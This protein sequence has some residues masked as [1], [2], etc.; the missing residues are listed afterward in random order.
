MSKQMT[1]VRIYISESDA[2]RKG[3]LMK[4]IMAVLHDQ[5]RVHG[6]TVFRGIAGFGSK[7]VVHTADLLRLSP[8]LPEVIEFYDDP[9][10]VAAAIEALNS[11][12]PAGHMISWQVECNTG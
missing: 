4:N 7:G 12:I 3:N 2:G 1:V 9:D 8:H 11:L 5:P 10:I 6:V